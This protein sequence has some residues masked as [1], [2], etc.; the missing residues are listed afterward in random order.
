MTPPRKG[1]KAVPFTVLQAELTQ[2]LSGL[3]REMAREGAILVG[4]TVSTIQQLREWHA[5]V[6]QVRKSVSGD[7]GSDRAKIIPFPP[8]S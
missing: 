4:E 3:I 1:P 2:E 8:P 5:Y 7:A 6:M